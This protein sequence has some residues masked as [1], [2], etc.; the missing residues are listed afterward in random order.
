MKKKKSCLFS[1][2]EV[3]EVTDFYLAKRV[4]K[5]RNNFLPPKWKGKCSSWDLSWCVYSWLLHFQEVSDHAAWNKNHFNTNKIGHTKFAHSELYLPVLQKKIA[6]L[7][8]FPMHFYNNL[9][10]RSTFFQAE[11]SIINFARVTERRI[12]EGK[13]WNPTFTFYPQK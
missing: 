3:E 1:N 8:H 11:I 6:I 7:V 9:R 12:R 13:S 4:K 2:D 5:R 10:Y